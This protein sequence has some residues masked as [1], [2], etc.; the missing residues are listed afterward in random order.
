MGNSSSAKSETM[1]AAGIEFE[2]WFDAY[3]KKWLP[4]GDYDTTLVKKVAW[5]AWVAAIEFAAPKK[6]WPWQ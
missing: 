5:Y 1:S 3:S 4:W 6:R 2:K